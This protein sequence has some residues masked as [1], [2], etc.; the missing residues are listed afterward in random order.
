MK[1]VI[2]DQ[3]DEKVWA[4]VTNDEMVA[5]SARTFMTNEGVRKDIARFKRLASSLR[6][7]RV[8]DE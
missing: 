7:A 4:L 8:K 2:K 3:G 6:F 5:F 1:F